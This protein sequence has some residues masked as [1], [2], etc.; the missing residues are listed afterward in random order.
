M[1]HGSFFLPFIFWALIFAC[2]FVNFLLET[3]HRSAHGRVSLCPEGAPHG[4][5]IVRS[6]VVSCSSGLVSVLSLRDCETFGKEFS[7]NSR[8]LCFA[9]RSFLRVKGSNNNIYFRKL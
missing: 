3:L 1:T 9:L 2:Y 4:R 5:P 6:P 8:V 7:Q